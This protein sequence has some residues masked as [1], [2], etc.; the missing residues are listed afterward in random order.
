[1]I[2]RS[3]LVPYAATEMFALVNDVDAYEDF[4]PWCKSSQVLS[5]GENELR[6][7]LRLARGG[8]EKSFVTRNRTEE[9][10]VIKMSLEKGPFHHLEGIWR[11]DVLDLQACKV[12]LHLEFEFSNRLLGLTFGPVFNQI[13]NSL[14]DAFCQRAEVIYG[15]R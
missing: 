9:G 12:S 2:D 13:A 10:E 6:A 4:L 3:A 11:F 1:M 7:E 5:R 8:L 15:K 14:V